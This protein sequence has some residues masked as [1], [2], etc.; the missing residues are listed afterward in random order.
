MSV[1]CTIFYFL[2]TFFI[3]QLA[4]TFYGLPIIEQTKITVQVGLIAIIIAAIL[5]LF[6]TQCIGINQVG[7]GIGTSLI[8]MF[9]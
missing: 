7:Q 1:F 5:S 2:S 3:I 9:L 4:P 6:I 8:N